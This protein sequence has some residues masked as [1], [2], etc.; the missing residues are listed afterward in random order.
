MISQESQDL[1]IDV[2]NSRMKLG[3]FAGGRLLAHTHADRADMSAVAGFLGGIQPAR[4][5]IGST[6]AHD[7]DFLRDLRSVAP[8]T[9]ITGPAGA[10]T[11]PSAPARPCLSVQRPR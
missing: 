9:V 3:L 2:G 6:A 11:G 1:V 8:L 4:I 5:A 10:P 7:E